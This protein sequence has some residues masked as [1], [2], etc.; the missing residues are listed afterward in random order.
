MIGEQVVVVGKHDW[1]NCV[2]SLLVKT[3]NQYTVGCNLN[4]GQTLRCMKVK[5]LSYSWNIHEISVQD[6]L[7]STCISTLDGIKK[8]FPRRSLA[9]AASAITSMWLIRLPAVWDPHYPSVF[10]CPS[11]F[12]FSLLVLYLGALGLSPFFQ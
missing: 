6:V 4:P 3:P 11:N 5:K 1:P 7:P 2:F 12:D 8:Q 10:R 9:L